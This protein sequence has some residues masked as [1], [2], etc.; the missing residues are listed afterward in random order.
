MSHIFISY[1]KIDI[2]FAR[3]LRAR[4]IAAG[5]AVWM[6]E[7]KLVPSERWWKTIE[8]NIK[9]CAAFIVVMSPNSEASDWVEREI[10]VAEDEK[11]PIFPVLL[12]GKRWSR[13][14]NIQY[15]NMQT[16]VPDTLSER[17]HD[18]L[19]N[20]LPPGTGTTPPPLPEDTVQSLPTRRP[21][22]T[23]LFAIGVGVLVLI[24]VLVIALSGIFNLP[25]DTPTPPAVVSQP[26]N[27]VTASPPAESQQLIAP[28]TPTADATREPSA[29]ERLATLNAIDTQIAATRTVQQVTETAAAIVAATVTEEAVRFFA[30]ETS[31][32]STLLARSFTPTFTRTPT[33]TRTSTLTPTPSPLDRAR[34]GVHTNAD[35]TPHS[36][37]DARGVPMMLV[38]AGCFR[39]GS[40]NGGSDERPVHEV[41]ITAPYWIDRT[42]VTQADFTRLGG[43]K[44][45]PNWFS[46]ADRPVERITWFEARD[47]CA[48]RGARLPTEAEWEYAARG[49]DALFYPWGNDFIAANAVHR[50][51]S[52]RQTANVMS[53]PGGASWVGAHDM[54]GNVWEWTSSLIQA[55]P[56]NAA[57]GREA[58]TGNRTDVPRVLRGGSWVNASVDLQAAYRGYA[59]PSF[60]D[61][62]F[63]FRCAL[64]S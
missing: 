49:P 58:D 29:A 51:N 15:E 62:Y 7:T 43:V 25:D 3:A 26:T 48:R 28:P 2:D 23:T 42:E 37:P 46:G 53:R 18:G 13:L 61:R 19:A 30:T 52:N 40:E 21:P 6:D 32:L 20:Y 5:F 8:R 16:G 57:D 54:A 33:P 1:S 9:N 11:R 4:L 10:L 38:P 34:A 27:T 22:R 39:M 12:S 35:W 47:F 24:A 55:Y 31:A 14:G 41:C 59:S 64:S 63:G 45:N 56:Y 50:G 60:V 36:E 44:A 17:F